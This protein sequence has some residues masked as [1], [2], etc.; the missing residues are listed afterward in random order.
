MPPT[1]NIDI[2]FEEMTCEKRDLHIYVL[3]HFPILCTDNHIVTQQGWHVSDW[4]VQEN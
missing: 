2:D 4:P 3:T 1:G